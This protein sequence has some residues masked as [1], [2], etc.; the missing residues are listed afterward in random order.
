MTIFGISLGGYLFAR[1]GR[2]PT[3]LIGAIL[4]I[5]A[6]SSTPISQRARQV[7]MRWAARLV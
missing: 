6:I 2:M 4:P 1:L 5:L 7:L 3:I